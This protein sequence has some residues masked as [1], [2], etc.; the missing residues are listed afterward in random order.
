MSATK[1]T[2]KKKGARMPQKPPSRRPK[3]DG[4]FPKRPRADGRWAFVVDL[5]TDEAGKRKRRTIYARSKVA[6]QQKIQDE[7]ARQGGT[8]RELEAGTVGEFLESWLKKTIKPNRA[9]ST[10]ALYDG[11]LRKHVL[12]IV[13]RARLER[14]D[15][16]AVDRLYQRMRDDGV[17][18]S[19]MNSCARILRAAFETRTKRSRTANPF[20]IVEVPKYQ[21]D[22]VRPLDV[23][24]AR[25][26]LAAAKGTPM[27]SLFVL[28][29]AAGLRLGEA[30]AVRWSDLDEASRT[31]SI[32]RALRDV[33]GHVSIEPTKTKR[34]RR[35]V[36]LNALAL[37]ALT[38][39]RALAKKE[40]HGSEYIHTGPTGAFLR[41]SY[42]RRIFFAPIVEDAGI[43]SATIHGLRHSFSTRLAD[44][45]VS[46]RTIGDAMGHSRPSVTLDTYQHSDA[47]SHRDAVDRLNAVLTGRKATA[48]QGKI[49]K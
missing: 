16:D 15:A 28:A 23:E 38:R 47:A 25:R 10:F 21:A 19:V 8:L 31:L 29:L 46:I 9:S 45:G 26:F 18:P 36:P 3:G 43:E 1:H 22:E 48:R 32:E 6:L 39:R 30:L 34:S 5:G 11:L 44:V 4:S 24:Q 14:F 27:E 13:S 17:T 7:R 35:R 2:S 37:A 41:P 12:S 40:G 33:K 20:R 49:P 42:V